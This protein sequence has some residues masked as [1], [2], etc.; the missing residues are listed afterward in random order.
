MSRPH[1]IGLQAAWHAEA[2][3]AAWTRSFGRPT[4]IDPGDRVWLVIERP[5]ACAAL[6][7]GWLLPPIAAGVAAWRHD[8]T[9]DLLHRNELRLDVPG[10]VVPVASSGRTPLPESLGTVAL[11]IEPTA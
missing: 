1:R 6:L 9:A 3:G 8:V 7:N 11:E 4:G 5:A 10:G 2:G